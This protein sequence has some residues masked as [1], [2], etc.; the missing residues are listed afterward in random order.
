MKLSRYEEKHK[1]ITEKNPELE[2]VLQEEIEN[3]TKELLKQDK[4]FSSFSRQQYYRL[5]KIYDLNAKHL[6]EKI[7]DALSTIAQCYRDFFMLGALRSPPEDFHKSA[8]AVV[9]LLSDNEK[10]FQKSD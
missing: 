1:I 4:E 2:K 6:N 10:S 7:Q 8:K 3:K 5:N 9:I